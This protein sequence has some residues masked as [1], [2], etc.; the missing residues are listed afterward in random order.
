MEGAYATKLD[1]KE[2]GDDAVTRRTQQF[3]RH[4]LH[5]VEVAPASL[6]GLGCG[7]LGLAKL[8]KFV[9]SNAVTKVS[10]ESIR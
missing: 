10:F 9:T 1:V 6:L 4:L 5:T 8:A 3:L 2:P 7:G